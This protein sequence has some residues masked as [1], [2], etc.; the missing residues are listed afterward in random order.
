M[1]SEIKLRSPVSPQEHLW[2]LESAP[3]ILVEYGDYE[4]PFS[5]QAVEIVKRLQQS[6]QSDFV[7]AFRNFPLMQIHPNATNAAKAVEA[8]ALQGKFWPLHDLFFANQQNLSM[9]RILALAKSININVSQFEKDMTSKEIDRRILENFY[10][11]ARSGVNGTPTFFINGFRYDGVLSFGALLN[12]LQ[13]TQQDPRAVTP[14]KFGQR[15][16]SSSVRN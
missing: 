5:R 12:A 15:S 14:P 9:D 7:F 6:L 11:G 4:C 13:S 8:A 3:M 2:G 1:I 10:S 16:T